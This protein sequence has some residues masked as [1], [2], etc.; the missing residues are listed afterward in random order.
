MA[1][2]SLGDPAVWLFA[3]SGAAK[4]NVDNPDMDALPPHLEEVQVSA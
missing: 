3:P 4:D 1:T 2:K